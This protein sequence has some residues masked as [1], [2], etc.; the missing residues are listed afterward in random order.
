LE[1]S[2]AP[3]ISVVICAYRSRARIDTALASLA[4]QDTEDP[5]EV[6]VVS[7]G[8]DDTPEYLARQ[9]PW[10]KVVS[11]RERLYPGPARNL[12]VRAAR[13][14]L[15]AFLPDDGVAV[16]DWL[17]RRI[18]MHRQGY[19]AV[20]GSITNGTPGH[21][22]GTA[23]YLLEYSA[24]LPSDR[25]LR[26]QEIPH[27]LSY[28]RALFDRHGF[29]PED[30]ETGE[31]TLFNRRLVEAGVR[32]GFDAQA[33][34]AHRNLTGLRAYLSHQRDHGRG[35]MQC[36][37]VHGF[38]SPI[39][40]DRARPLRT[41]WRAFVTYPLYRWRR[42]V[43]RARRAGVSW[44]ASYLFL[45]PLIWAGIWATSMGIARE[46]LVLARRSPRG[47]LWPEGVDG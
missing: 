18:E 44:L 30:T 25:L 11:R 2:G 29:F 39:G 17:R 38:A 3:I 5:F 13:A 27:C 8:G 40:T 34:L 36:V 12:G 41:F 15:V 14:D 33:R 4:A 42:S 6:I 23:G 26:E 24:L 47:E 35:L 20:G 43:G 31:D 10:V 37:A 32:I 16:S 22:V 1:V 9:H 28:R 7:S 19:D 21:P 45:S 46:Y